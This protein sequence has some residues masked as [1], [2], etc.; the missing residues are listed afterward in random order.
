MSYF[1]QIQKLRLN[2]NNIKF[3]YSSSLRHCHAINIDINRFIEMKIKYIRIYFK[4]KKVR[5]YA[6]SA[7]LQHA[8]DA[9]VTDFSSVDY[10]FNHRFLVNKIIHTA[11]F[12]KLKNS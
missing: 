10:H 11:E 5:I 8:V 12:I 1:V 4:N 9:L 6:L 7:N 2:C 3:K